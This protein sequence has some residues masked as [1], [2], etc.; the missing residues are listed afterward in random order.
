MQRAL[1]SQVRFF[2]PPQCFTV[3][4]CKNEVKVILQYTLLQLNRSPVYSVSERITF[5]SVPQALQQLLQETL[6]SQRWW[7]LD[8]AG[9]TR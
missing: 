1:I 9:L 3:L 4:P 2:F 6:S 5:L 8:E 7:G